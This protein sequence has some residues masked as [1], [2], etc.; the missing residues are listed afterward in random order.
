MHLLLVAILALPQ[1]ARP[2]PQPRSTPPPE[3]HRRFRLDLHAPEQGGIYFSAWM[4]PDVITG[5]DGSDG[6]TVT[7]RRRYVWSD[8]CRWEATESLVPTAADRYAYSYREAPL[9]CPA[10]AVADT[11]ATTPRDGYVTVEPAQSAA[12]L[13]PLVAWVRGWGPRR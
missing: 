7:Y 11:G 3:V 1:F 9:S 8:G 13:T 4:A 2:R 10:G 12:R 6:E 5:H